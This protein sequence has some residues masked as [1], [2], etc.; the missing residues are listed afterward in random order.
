MMF[1][2]TLTYFQHA[3]QE[4]VQTLLT[5]ATVPELRATR[6]PDF[7]SF[8]LSHDYRPDKAKLIDMTNNR[9]RAFYLCPKS[10]LPQFSYETIAETDQRRRNEYEA[11]V[12]K[13]VGRFT[14]ALIGQ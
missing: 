2:F 12:K 13:C 14:N 7:A 3:I 6:S 1:L 11:A 5:F 10:N 4:L 9:G 8:Q